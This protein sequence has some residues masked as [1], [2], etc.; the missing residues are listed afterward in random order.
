MFVSQFKEAMAHRLGKEVPSI[1]PATGD[2]H[3]FTA[4]GK[5]WYHVLL[6]EGGEAAGYFGTLAGAGEDY[7][8]E[9]DP[10]DRY[11]GNKLWERVNNS[12]W[13]F[14]SKRR[15][16]Y[17]E[18]F[19]TAWQKLAEHRDGCHRV[20]GEA[21]YRPVRSLDGE[22]RGM[23][24]TFPEF[25]IIDG[26]D[27]N[28]GFILLG[29]NLN[30]QVERIVIAHKWDEAETIHKAT[31]LPVLFVPNFE[32][33]C[34]LTEYIS[35]HLPE[36]EALIVDD[37]TLLSTSEW[38]ARPD[39]IEPRDCGHGPLCRHRLVTVA[40]IT[41]IESQ[42]D[43]FD[44]TPLAAP[45]LNYRLVNGATVAA[46]ADEISFIAEGFIPKQ[47]LI[48][49]HAP[50]GEGK[51]TLALQALG[52]V[53][54]GGTFLGSRV[55]KRPVVVC[56]YENAP[57]AL[58]TLIERIEGADKIHFLE[59]PPQLDQ[60]EWTKLKLIVSKLDKPVILIDTLASA[61]A[62]SDIGSN[63]DFAPVMQKLMELRNMGATVMF[64]NHTLKRDAHKFIGAQV[65][66]SQSDHVVSLTPDAEDSYRLGTSG[67]TR[68]GYFE[69]AIKFDPERKLFVAADNPDQAAI[70]SILSALNPESPVGV[71]QISAKT[72]IPEKKLRALLDRYEDK[73]W[74]T[75]RGNKNSKLYLRV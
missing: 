10:I 62:S 7:E 12:W 53:A 5:P 49:F 8:F 42:K 30:A 39:G 34:D 37:P 3:T 50:P 35:E 32:S 45:E 55:E 72:S 9:S 43:D 24:R 73:L 63:A 11:L 31:G 40:Q 13:D 25:Q 15:R 29:D 51:T 52:A 61:C 6:V 36:T 38:K 23:A 22:I 41:G 74:Q 59:D 1:I 48:E 28:G 16:E 19:G 68:Y 58:K 67:K 57:S 66:M 4:E 54:G 46:N 21:L 70:D 47:S 65:L 71:P 26:S 75:K 2:V 17:Q 14:K 20:H 64:L 56:N 27:F 33:A 18:W 44:L 60:T 69:M